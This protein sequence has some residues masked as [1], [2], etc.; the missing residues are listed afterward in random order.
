MKPQERAARRLRILA[1]FQETGSLRATRRRLGH[2]LRTIRRVLSGQDVDPPVRSAPSASSRRPSKLDPYRPMIR[3]LVLEDRLTAVLVL[4]EIRAVGFTGG[5]SA[6]KR[7]VRQIRPSPKVK[8]TIWVEHPPGAEGQVD[9]SPYMVT[10]G[11]EE[12]LVHAFS[13]VLPFSRWMF[14][15][16]TL[17]EQ[18]ETLLRCHEEAFVDLDGHPPLMT[19]DN[20]TTVGRHISDDEVWINPR[21]EAYAREHDFEIGL[22]RPGRP[23][24][25]APV[26]RPFH[27]IQHNCLK[28]RRFR[29][30]SLADLNAHADWWCREVANVRCHGTTRERPIDRLARERAYF[31]PL[32]SAPPDPFRT[33]ARTVGSDFCVAVDT[34]RYSLSPRFAGC[35]ATVRLYFKRLEILVEGTVVTAHALCTGRHQRILLPEHEEEFRRNTPSRR[36]LEQAFLRLGESARDYYE[37]LKAQRGGG[38]G[39]HLQRILALADRHGAAVVTGAMAHA[40]RFGNY[41][42]EAVAR[43]ISG[44]APRVPTATGDAPLPPERIRLWLEGMDVEGRDLSDFDRLIGHEEDANGQE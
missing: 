43:V 44:K 7:F 8:V 2:S 35:P 14:V 17:D 19:Y 16:F 4:E 40:A 15:R 10:L 39:Y 42:A 34:N 31:K 6:L 28:R 25:H 18:L 27:Y 36:L 9:W 22:T 1:V 26:E 21:F 32:A 29:F 13:F 33:L 30:D 23:N 11:E 3:R 41:G 5:Y 38:A 12:R 37:G 24:D 20:M